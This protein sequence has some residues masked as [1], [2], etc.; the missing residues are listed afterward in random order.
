MW[1]QHILHFSLRTKQTYSLYVGVCFGSYNELGS[2]MRHVRLWL[3]SAPCG[4]QHNEDG[5]PVLAWIGFHTL[6][7]PAHAGNPVLNWGGSLSES[8]ALWIFHSWRISRTPLAVLPATSIIYLTPGHSLFHSS[9]L[10]HSSFKWKS[11]VQASR[12]SVEW[13]AL[14]AADC[15]HFQ[16]CVSNCWVL[17][18]VPDTASSFTRGR[19]DNKE[20]EITVKIMKQK[21]IN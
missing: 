6:H 3:S 10:Y 4:K 19:A 20:Q 15:P 11:F 9:F 18:S 12:I 7:I 8:W 16:S 1:S 14:T 2:R 5:I 13:H 21:K 17:R